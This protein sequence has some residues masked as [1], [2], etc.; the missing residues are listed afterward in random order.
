MS[1]PTRLLVLTAALLLAASSAHAFTFGDQ[2]TT[3]G[4]GAQSRSFGSTLM[5]PGSEIRNYSGA[6][7]TTPKTSTTTQPE[8]FSFKFGA[9]S[10]SAE[11]NRRLAPPKWSTDPLYLDKGD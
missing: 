4:S 11:T 10:L 2:T 1:H 3:N 5:D 8:G 6:D 9:G 7:L